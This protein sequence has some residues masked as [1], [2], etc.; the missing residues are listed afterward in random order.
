[1]SCTRH[2]EVFAHDSFAQR[3]WQQTRPGDYFIAALFLALALSTFWL[4]SL[5]SPKGPAAPRARVFVR[6]HLVKEVDL[7]QAG[8]LAIECVLGQV[9]LAVAEGGIRVAAST[10]PNQHCV[11]QGAIRRPQQMLVCVPNHLLVAIGGQ[12]K[13]NLDAIT[14]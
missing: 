9:S 12:E 4:E 7:R 11:R 1:M 10:C 6:N 13:T 8:T 14:F 3:L 5:S 2:T